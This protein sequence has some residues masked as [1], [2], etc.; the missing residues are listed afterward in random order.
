[1]DVFLTSSTADL[2]ES[3][4]TLSAVAGGSTSAFRELSSGSY[5]LRVTGSGDPT[6]LRLD[7]P[8]ITLADRQ[9]ASLVLTAGASGVLLDG[10]FIPQQGQATPM[11]N[12]Q[13]RV[14]VAAGVD[15][16]GSVGVSLGSRT[17][18]GALRSPS[19]GPYQ[20]VD[21]GSQTLTVR[22][23]GSELLTTTRAFAAGSDHTLLVYGAAGAGELR[24]IQ[25]DNRLPSL[26]TRSKLRLVH[27]AAGLDALTLAV[28]YLALVS[29]T[30]AG[31]A[32]AS[33][34]VTSSSTARVDVT[35]ASAAAAV[36]TA[37]E[38]NLQG[39]AV[40]SVFVL[41]GNAS[42]TGLIRKER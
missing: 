7:I 13:A 33:S 21:A 10:V 42:A 36:Y 28:D 18:V 27:G 19:V 37:E 26:A 1:V 4:A 9:H 22:V 8:A 16:A 23:N 2:G 14:R 35:S 38:V 5:R 3:A 25:D 34:T 32:S 31:T 29:D 17:L 24:V 39:Q 11:K 30:V 15:G 41:G 6:D 40:Y 12:T 20:L